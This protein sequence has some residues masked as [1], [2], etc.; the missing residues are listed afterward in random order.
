MF[1]HPKI[2]YSAEEAGT[3]IVYL[4]RKQKLYRREL[5][6]YQSYGIAAY[7]IAVGKIQTL[8]FVEDVSVQ[9]RTVWKLSLM[10]SFG[11]LDPRQLRDVVEDWIGNC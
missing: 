8:A 9:W 6:Q 1:F 3:V 11:K 2:L 4:P 5:G 10:G 7:R